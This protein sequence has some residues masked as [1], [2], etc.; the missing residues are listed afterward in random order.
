L[1]RVVEV[2]SALITTW[3]FIG[4]E[5]YKLNTMYLYWKFHK[6]KYAWLHDIEF[7]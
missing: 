2:G 1:D 7:K 5:P 6:S 4:S 3:H